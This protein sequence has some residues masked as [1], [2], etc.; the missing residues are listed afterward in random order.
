M[1]HAVT[2]LRIYSG[3]LLFNVVYNMAAGILN[4]AGN[5]KRSLLYLAS[6]AMTN[7]VLDLVL[8]GLFR[9]GVEGAAIATDISQAV[10]CVLAL[11]FL[12]R[13]QADYRISFR[14]LQIEK[15]M[16]VHIIKIGLPTGIQN[17]VIS[18]A[19]ILLQSSVNGFGPT[20]MAGFGAYMKVDGF[21]ILP[22]TSFSMAVTTFVGQNYGAGKL[23]R[24]KKGMWT[25]LIMGL[26]YTVLTG[27]LLLFFSV[28]VMRL[29]NQDPEV[30]AC[31]VLAMRYFC[32]FYWLL[33]I[34]A[35][36]SWNSERNWKIDS[37]YGDSIGLSMLV[38][39]FLGQIH[40]A[41]FFIY[42]RRLHSLSG[43]MGSG[44]RYDGSV[45]LE[46]E[47]A[48]NRRE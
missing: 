29:F 47:V 28:P 7:I 46:G 38:P 39:D 2:Y 4:A 18:L 21:N 42:C 35:W 13:V 27:A 23:D 24:V 19:N 16:A 14:A 34:P 30:V 32:P 11:H 1:A 44:C 43:V 17:M 9:F 31:G 5:S 45:C 37:P 36:F 25:V 8:I 41:L 20:A 12:L 33:S 22:V 15:K 40:P 10:S 6:A 3:G 26:G 48:C